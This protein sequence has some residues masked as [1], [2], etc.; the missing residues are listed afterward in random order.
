MCPEEQELYVFVAKEVAEHLEP[1]F[2]NIGFNVDD[3]EFP[4]SPLEQ[5]TPFV[6]WR[7]TY[8][9]YYCASEEDDPYY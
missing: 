5:Y 4:G 8:Q 6:M 9:A 3:C 2:A 1:E 7:H